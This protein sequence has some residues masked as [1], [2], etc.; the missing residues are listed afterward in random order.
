MVIM[1]QFRKIVS[2]DT[3]VWKEDEE[4]SY[5]V[6]SAYSAL[7]HNYAR[8]NSKLFKSLW[9]IK[10]LP[11]TQHFIWKML[12]DKILAKVNLE[13]KGVGTGNSM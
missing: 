6:K 9:T 7:Q 5:L 2:K 3:W 10:A 11:S 1:E 12:L 13:Y 8:E 4:G